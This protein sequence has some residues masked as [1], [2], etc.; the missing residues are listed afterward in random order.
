MA[1]G[2]VIDESKKVR[3]FLSFP[4]LTRELRPPSPGSGAPTPAGGSPIGQVVEAALRDVL[5]WRPRSGDAHGF[6]AALNQ[7]FTTREVAGRVEYQWTPHSYS[8]GIQADLG[9][10]TGAQASLLSRARNTLDQVLPLL[11]GLSP[12]RTDPDAEDTS[13]TRAI[14]RSALIELAG[15]LGTLGGPRVP[16][17]DDLFTQLLGPEP[18]EQDAEQIRGQLQVL[19]DRFGLTR[20]AI[21]TVAEEQSYTNFLLIVDYVKGLEQSWNAQRALF[22]RTSGD[23]FLGTQL[24]LLSRELAV[25]SESVQ[26]L[27][28]LMDS[29][30]LGPAERGTT[31]LELG[32][33]ANPVVL[34]VAELFGWVDRF[35]T[36]E[37]PRLIQDAGK[38]GVAVFRSTLRR[39]IELVSDA[40]EL[41]SGGGNHSNPALQLESIGSGLSSLVQ[42][43]ETAQSLAGA[44]RR[45]PPE[46]LEVTGLS[47]TSGNPEEALVN[48]VVRGSGFGPDSWVSLG[49]GIEIHDVRLTG[50][51]LVVTGKVRKEASGVKHL[52]VVTDEGEVATLLDAFTVANTRQ[53]PATSEA[54]QIQRVLRHTLPQAGCLELTLLGTG[55]DEY[56]S[57]PVFGRGLRVLKVSRSRTRI[58]AKVQVLPQ[59]RGVKPAVVVNPGGQTAV[60]REAFSV[61]AA[62]EGTGVLLPVSDETDS[63][64][65]LTTTPVAGGDAAP[66]KPPGRPKG[67]GAKR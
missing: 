31:L 48:V 26:E 30:F 19:R 42:H 25:I 67:S 6:V 22:S 3:Q 50:D 45:T 28:A 27:Y 61:L 43:M 29:L 12:L 36:E 35:V 51:D 32:D 4:V 8:A 20:S 24:V 64:T 57:M 56:S 11:D 39:L 7:S 53:I 60:F 58:V 59:A 52:T 54:P 40:L 66:E 10:I 2:N 9:T 37:A 49:R 55:F 63:E 23:A 14:V 38:D 44:V 65:Q 5:G 46:R 34:T 47:K 18:R 21:N 1:N 62:E 17:V 13:S 16:R 41:S 15:E 33:S